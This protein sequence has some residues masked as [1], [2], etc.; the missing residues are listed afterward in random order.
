MEETIILYFDFSE[1]TILERETML[2]FFE[3]EAIIL[4]NEDFQFID[5]SIEK[6]DKWTDKSLIYNKKSKLKYLRDLVNNDDKGFSLNIFQDDLKFKSMDIKMCVHLESYWKNNVGASK[7]TIGLNHKSYFKNYNLTD[8]KNLYERILLFLQTQTF[9][10]R[11][12]F[13]F[14]LENN[15]FPLLFANGIGS[16]NLNATEEIS[17]D[18][19]ANCRQLA[20]EKVWN[21]FYLNLLTEKHFKKGTSLDQLISVVGSNNVKLMSGHILMVFNNSKLNFDDKNSEQLKV[22]EFLNIC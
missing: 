19:W 1:N 12:G 4:F 5:Y 22:L 16:Y 7:L 3:R 13:M 10:V 20:D 17:V 8:L 2:N 14:S 11:Y 15:K 9:D 6:N 18:K 21:I